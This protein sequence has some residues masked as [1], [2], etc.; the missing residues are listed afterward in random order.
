MN[1]GEFK[2]DLK[3]L[4]EKEYNNDSI[5][6][7][8][9]ESDENDKDSSWFKDYDKNPKDNELDDLSWLKDYDKDSKDN[10]LDDLSWLIDYD[11][12]SENNKNDDLSWM[13]DFERNSEENKDDSLKFRNKNNELIKK[14]EYPYEMRVDDKFHEKNYEG[15]NDILDEKGKDQNKIDYEKENR[16]K[17][18]DSD[19]KAVYN[20]LKSKNL[21]LKKISDEI[22]IDFKGPLYRNYSMSKKSFDKLK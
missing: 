4:D 18:E 19:L 22:G 3:E 21:S 6:E 10:E 2:E 12:Y 17:I 20:E 9:K 1:G 15:I 16:I 14:G 8:S 11:E 7:D 5:K 13:K